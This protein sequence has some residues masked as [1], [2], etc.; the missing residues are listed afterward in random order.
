[1][2]DGHRVIFSRTGSRDLEER[3]ITMAAPHSV[4]PVHLLGKHLVSALPC[5]L[6]GMLAAFANAMM[7]A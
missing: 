3:I 5:L 4:D 1:M 6:R 7:S 2:G